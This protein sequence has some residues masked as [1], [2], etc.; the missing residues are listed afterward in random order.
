[1]IYYCR[2][3]TF[4]RCA[5]PTFASRI[6]WYIY[7]Y[8]LYIYILYIYKI[9]MARAAANGTYRSIWTHFSVSLTV[10]YVEASRASRSPR[11]SRI[12]TKS[13]RRPP[14][15]SPRAKSAPISSWRLRRNFVS[16][17]TRPR[18]PRS[19]SLATACKPIAR[20]TRPATTWTTTTTTTTTTWRF[21]GYAETV[22]WKVW[23]IT[24][25]IIKVD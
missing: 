22:P 17:K 11:R 12:A 13:R 19:P 1:M 9:H 20:T 18:G 3:F 4:I 6:L 8:I 14:I 16:P 7:I 10:S 24:K 21:R 25:V 5:A 23:P 15:Q 2:C